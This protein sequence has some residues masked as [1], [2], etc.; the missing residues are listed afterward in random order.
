MAK[1]NRHYKVG[2][3]STREGMQP[4]QIAKVFAA[5]K[6]LQ[7]SDNVDDEEECEF[8]HGNCCGGDHEGEVLAI[9]LGFK[10]IAHPSN[11]GSAYSAPIKSGVI[12]RPAK[13]PLVR[14]KDIVDE[15]DVLIACP[16]SSK[17]ALRS[18]TWSTIRYA[19]K[20]H[21]QVVLLVP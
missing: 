19:K 13:D 3:T 11:L 5:L 21:K 16:K 2:F 1:R 17:E 6:D 20:K 4:G 9:I 8:H 10:V 14:N 18:G 7:H 15:C 12:Y